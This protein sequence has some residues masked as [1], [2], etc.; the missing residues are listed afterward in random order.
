MNR[1]IGGEM[2]SQQFK[3]LVMIQLNEDTMENVIQEVKICC[4]KFISEIKPTYAITPGDALE[5]FRSICA[6]LNQ[7]AIESRGI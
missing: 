3:E 4:S 1:R 2:T 5:K 7:A 6:L